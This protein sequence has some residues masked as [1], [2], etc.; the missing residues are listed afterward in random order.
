MPSVYPS[1]ARALVLGYPG[2]PLLKCQF[3]NLLLKELG[4]GNQMLYFKGGLIT[5]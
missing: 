3:V 4:R 5:P 2:V 1:T